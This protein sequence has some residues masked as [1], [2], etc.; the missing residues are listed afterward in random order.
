MVS[1]RHKTSS[2]SRL[3]LCHE[4]GG[5]EGTLNFASTRIV[6]LV[7]AICGDH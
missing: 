3:C 1:A 6:V 5:P 2:G 4:L 7:E